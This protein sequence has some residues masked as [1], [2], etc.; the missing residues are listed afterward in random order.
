MDLTF[1]KNTSM[2][3]SPMKEQQPQ[4]EEK[5]A[6]VSKQQSSTNTHA[7]IKELDSAQNLSPN[8]KQ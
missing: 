6:I 2:A 4:K 8:I 7:Q 5:S 3:E 1:S